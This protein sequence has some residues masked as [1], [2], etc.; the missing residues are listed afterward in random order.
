METRARV[1]R[2]AAFVAEQLSNGWSNISKYDEIDDAGT[3]LETEVDELLHVASIEGTYGGT[4]SSIM[5]ALACMSAS[6]ADGHE[7]ASG[8]DVVNDDEQ[9][10]SEVVFEYVADLQKQPTSA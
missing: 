10:L 9:T 7:T 4:E 6:W 8:D 5:D 3:R 2:V 1:D